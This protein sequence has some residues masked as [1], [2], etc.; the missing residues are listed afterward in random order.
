MTLRARG[1]DFLEYT[2]RLFAI[3]GTL[4]LNR[5]HNSVPG[6]FEQLQSL[7]RRIKVRMVRWHV[8]SGRLHVLEVIP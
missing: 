8:P 6:T 5:P 7:I 3:D 4:V 2:V 1:I